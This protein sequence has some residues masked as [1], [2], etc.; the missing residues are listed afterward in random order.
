MLVASLSSFLRLALLFGAF[1]P[2][3]LL[4]VSCQGGGA[5][6]KMA[7]KDCCWGKKRMERILLLTKKSIMH[8]VICN[9]LMMKASHVGIREGFQKK[10]NLKLHLPFRRW[11]PPPLMA[12]FPIQ[13]FTPLFSLA[14]ESY[15]YETD[16][17]LLSPVIIGSKL[18]F[19]SSSGRW[20]P[21]I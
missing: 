13:F 10:G 21:T 2:A 9:S 16:F 8:W 1:L 20:L 19:I 6:G 7:L 4:P 14:I 17:T 3:M 11:T 12:Q 18:T 5:S 15:I